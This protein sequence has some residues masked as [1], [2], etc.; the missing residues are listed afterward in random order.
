MNTQKERDLRTRLDSLRR[1]LVVGGYKIFVFLSSVI[2]TRRPKLTLETALGEDDCGQKDCQLQVLPDNVGSTRVV[3]PFVA[4]IGVFVSHRTCTLTCRAVEHSSLGHEE[5]DDSLDKIEKEDET[6]N[7][8]NGVSLAA[9]EP[10]QTRDQPQHL[11]HQNPSAQ[12]PK[13]ALSVCTA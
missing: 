8:G 3:E 11:G 1:S 13:T 7:D 10:G 4:I 6:S 9:M 2:T 12:G 5:Q